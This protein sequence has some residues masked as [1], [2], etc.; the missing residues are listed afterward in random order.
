MSN[1][2]LISAKIKRQ[3][4]PAIYKNTVAFAV[5]EKYFPFSLFVANQILENEIE[6]DFDILICLPSLDQ[7]PSEWKDSPIRF[8]EF[9]ITGIDQL[10]IGNLSLAAYHRLFLPSLF[11][12]DYQNILYLDADVYITKPFINALF[13]NLKNDFIICAAPDVANILIFSLSQPELIA[14]IKSYQEKN[15]IY[16]NSGVLLINSQKFNSNKCL[17]R[18]LKYA[19]ENLG[20][21]TYHDQTALNCALQENLSLLP[22][23]KN[24]QS[25]QHI[26]SFI[27]DFDPEII[28]FVADRKPWLTKDGL[29]AR[30]HNEYISFLYKNFKD[31]KFN[32]T[33]NL[34]YEQRLKNPKY[35]NI[36]RE[37]VSRELGRLR[38]WIRKNLG[39]YKK[40][41]MQNRIKEAL[42]QF[43]SKP[44]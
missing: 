1:I 29:S 20:D 39:K 37:L 5:D 22:F 36:I 42:T 21:L 13:K 8:C 24:W 17:E 34:A 6:R 28:H 14:Y 43:N 19:I 33:S 4:K 31:L 32:P 30:Y 2:S 18:T 16:R 9:E 26:N 23:N 10:P 11:H 12:E 35:K 27:E 41:E 40:N 38:E 44:R 25:H 3:S 15:H 7:I